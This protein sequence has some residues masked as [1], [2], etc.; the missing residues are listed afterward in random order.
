MSDDG[1]IQWRLGLPLLAASVLACGLALAYFIWLGPDS[2]H[3][4]K[5]ALLA[6]AALS[7]VVAILA[8]GLMFIAQRLHERIARLEQ[9]GGGTEPDRAA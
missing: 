6:L 7:V 5:V 2:P 9:R 4:P 8:A 1:G 3:I